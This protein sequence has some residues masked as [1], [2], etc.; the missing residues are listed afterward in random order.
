MTKRKLTCYD[1]AIAETFDRNQI[2]RALI[3]HR[4]ESVR[5]FPKKASGRRRLPKADSSA[6]ILGFLRSAAV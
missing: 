3:Y 4:P 5:S 6:F 2:F 1:S